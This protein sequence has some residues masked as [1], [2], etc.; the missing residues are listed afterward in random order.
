MPG[1]QMLLDNMPD[2]PRSRAEVFI[3]DET[4]QQW[5]QS[6]SRARPMFVCLDGLSCELMG[7]LQE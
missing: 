4:E 7:E 6:C 5:A 3:K 2:S 1:L